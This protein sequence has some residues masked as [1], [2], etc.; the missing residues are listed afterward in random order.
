M[1]DGSAT[2][3]QDSKAQTGIDGLD[4]ILRGGLPQNRLYVVEGSPGSGK[5]TLAL[6]FLLEGIRNGETVLYVTLSETAEELYEVARSHKWSLEGIH[7]L[8]LDALAERIRED[9]DY[10][11][12]HPADVELVETTRRIREEVERIRPTRVALDSVSE[13]KIL[14]QTIARYRREILGFKQFFVGKR[15]TVM[16]LDDLTSS[17]NEQQLQSI[18]HGVIR[19]ERETRDYGTTRRQLHIVKM[20]AVPFRDGLHDFVIREGGIEVFPR[21]AVSEQSIN[22]RRT[23]GTIQ[24][25]VSELDALLGNG[26]DRGSST[27]I[28][29]P[30]GSG[31]TTIT[32][33]FML[34]A[35]ERGEPVLC[36]L[37]EERYETFL[38]RAA[39]LG[40][41]F[42]SYLQ[43]G[44]LELIQIDPA[45]VS[46][47]EFANHIHRRVEARGARMV[48][49]DSLNGYINAMPNERFLMIQMH[50]LLTYLGQMGVVTLLVMAQH[51]MM[52]A[53]GTMPSPIDV[54][55]LADTVILLRYF[56]AQGAIRQAIS[57]VKKRRSAHERTIR[58]MQLTSKGIM[59]GEPLKEFEGVLTGVPRYRGMQKPLLKES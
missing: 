49:I 6:Q 17:K 1:H 42:D 45:E 34:A 33:Q 31:N 28:L 39:G 56:E 52:G 13:L 35:L 10:T 29:G 51:G 46:P 16:V 11:V 41:D 59:V 38:Q 50:E 27:L 18:A 48:V 32:A 9:T 8:E 26:I 2:Q 47:G 19:M 5:T 25:G 22:G 3:I 40:M 12:Y 24:S 4:K 57:V 44:L 23:H 30:A 37:F 7:L 54:S 58:E 53:M 15:C 21:L 36:Y 14:S 55:F 20:R 43:A